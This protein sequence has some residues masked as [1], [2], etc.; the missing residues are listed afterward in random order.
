[1]CGKR[2]D[3]R[4]EYTNWPIWGG[5]FWYTFRGRLVYYILSFTTIYPNA[6]KHIRYKIIMK[7]Y[8]KKSF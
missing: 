1:M 4:P 3:S 5:E 7:P 2:L 8:V 6:M